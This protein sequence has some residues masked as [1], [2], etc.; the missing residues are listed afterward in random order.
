MD[1]QRPPTQIKKA[2]P[3]VLLAALFNTI[4]ILF[5]KMA[6]QTT[7]I[8]IILFARYLTTL[9]IILP[10]VYFNPVHQKVS[11]FLKTDRPYLHLIRDILGLTSVF[12]YFY[13]ART[14]S[15]ADATVLFSTAPLF[16]P[17]IAFFWGNIKI[18]HR[19]WWGMSLGFL[20]VLLMLH[21]GREIFQPAALIGL[22]SGLC[23]AIVY[24]GSRYL[25]YS[26]PPLRNMFYY[27]AIGTFI[28]F[29]LILPGGKT[30]WQHFDLKVLW[31]LIGVG[32]FA[33]LYQWCFTE[34]TRYAPVRLTTPL[35][36]ASVIFALFLDWWLWQI[37]PSL[38]SLSSIILIIC[39]AVLLVWLY[40]EEDYQLRR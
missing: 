22:F 38:L 26:E 15:L 18:I 28:A 13:A 14:L 9:I 17:I 8:V 31:L 36:Y 16:I 3:L 34:S 6:S 2:I 39:G 19:L 20:G 12:C 7:P 30:I 5:A 40:P 33:Y 10:F 29:L 4:M 25:S 37:K 1:S 21:P 24:V 35:L 32:V 11:Q 23:A 27:F